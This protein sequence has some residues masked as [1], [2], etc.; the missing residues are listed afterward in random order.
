MIATFVVLIIVASSLSILFRDKS[1]TR[2]FEIGQIY[3]VAKTGPICRTP[4]V[5]GTARENRVATD[6]Q[7]EALGCLLLDPAKIAKVALIDKDPDVL[8]VRVL[9]PHQKA[10]TFE[11]WTDIQTLGSYPVAADQ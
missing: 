5:L 3:P 7:A 11:G 8:K 1:P 4:K 2:P 10:D 9:A 6:D